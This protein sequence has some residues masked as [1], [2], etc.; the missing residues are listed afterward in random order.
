M[1]LIGME[2][3]RSN[4]RD[5]Q[6]GSHAW[7][8]S[9]DHIS[10]FRIL[11][12]LNTSFTYYPTRLY[13]CDSTIFIDKTRKCRSQPM[14]IRSLHGAREECISESVDVP[15]T[16]VCSSVQFWLWHLPTSLSRWLVI[17]L[18]PEEWLLLFSIPL[19]R[20]VSGKKTL[21]AFHCWKLLACIRPLYGPAI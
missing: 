18:R 1:S 3:G 14:K 21:H 15:F 2:L 12:W 7:C 4:A 5:P 20:V 16:T 13:F 10:P 17:E 19:S 11:A 6:P 9:H 8:E